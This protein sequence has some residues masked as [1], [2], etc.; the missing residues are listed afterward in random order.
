MGLN[1]LIAPWP[2]VVRPH[3][4]PGLATCLQEGRLC[5]DGK[6]L[7]LS[8][9][10]FEALALAE[11]AVASGQKIVL[12]PA[13]PLAPLAELIAAGTHIAD[14]AQRYNADHIPRPT[15]KHVVVVTTD[16][17]A[18]GQY[19][20]LGV[21]YPGSSSVA[22]LR[23]A[24]PAATRGRDGV[25][26]VLGGGEWAT[27]FVSSVEDVSSQGRVDLAVIELPAKGAQR[28]LNARYPVVYVVRDPSDGLLAQL[29]GKVPVFCWDGSDLARVHSAGTP[30]PRL[31]RRVDGCV[32]VVP[33][34]AHGVCENAALFW[35]DVGPLS[36]GRSFVAREVSRLAFSLFHDLTGLA[37]PVQRYEELSG[38]I[39]VRL[40]A[41][42]SAVRL[43]RGETRE[44]YLP[45]VEAEL[46]DLARAIGATPPKHTALL[47]L[48]ARL[49]DAG[50]D[51]MLVART[52]ELARLYQ[53]EF[54]ADRVLSRARVTSLGALAEQPPADAAVLT[55]MAP[56]WGRWIYR[57]G[58]AREIH[59]LAYTPEGEIE[60]VAQGFDEAAMVRRTVATQRSLET[61]YGR[62]AMK[63]RAWT[64]LTGDRPLVAPGTDGV[65]PPR[66][67]DDAADAP[68]APPVDVPPG[69]WDGE[70]WLLPLEPGTGTGSPAPAP[71]AIG[72][73]PLHALVPAVRVT[74]A[75]GRWA[76]MAKDSTVTR[77]RP[78]P[79]SVDVAVPLATL[80]PGDQLVFFDG[81]GRKDLLGKV[82][83]VAEEVPDLAV[84]AAW[85]SY[86]RASLAR[87]YAQFGTYEALTYALHEQGCR[88]QTQ[89]VRLWVVGATIG[90]ED[91]EDVRRVGL[92]MDDQALLAGHR[93]I[94]RAMR[95]LRGAHVRLGRR[96]ADMARD[97]APA[98]LAGQLDMDEVVDDRTGLTVADFR[99][100]IDVLTV[101]SMEPVGDV[102]FV[103][104]GP[105][106]R[107][108]EE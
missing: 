63:D 70:G 56:T 82:L 75:D 13:D 71:P 40:A 4:V 90:P 76:L 18:R 14:M 36:A 2:G 26:R 78:H 84:A 28:L 22:P 44:L 24:V 35:Q 30:S 17:H 107:P 87:G 52:A 15:T 91:E 38:P 37:L 100:S 48:L 1:G 8:E 88:V 74:F 16:H 51:V 47:S 92:A 45:M 81:D 97:V 106:N 41:L 98:A 50:Q 21:K 32:T 64:R 83:E 67:T 49:V 58:I 12:C 105:L 86:W 69:L 9:L 31:A 66:V 42:G 53:S 25:V 23:R 95:S 59:V 68:S 60:S 96:L 89:S 94:C 102:P 55:G 39:R 57:S 34:P 3:A 65:S 27:V 104:V 33:V 101:A 11:W 61:W 54:A 62:P 108:G 19:R 29:A 7:P 10:E 80:R 6:R 46:R 72:G 77:L 5:R 73:P 79:G 103:L 43:A 93:E 99:D 20:S 85:L